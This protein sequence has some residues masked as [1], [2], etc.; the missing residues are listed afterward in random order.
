MPFLNFESR[1]FSEAEITAVNDALQNLHTT[2]A[3]KLASL[4]PEER[5]QYGS[6]NE[7][8]KLL[9]NK[10]NDYKN[11]N[12]Q[13]SSPEVDWEEFS[14]DHE[15]RSFLESVTNT[16]TELGRGLENAKILHDWDNYQASLIDYQYS[17]Y[18]NDSGSTG[19]H[20]K[21]QEIKQFFGRT[22]SGKTSGD[23][24]VTE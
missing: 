23:S 4:T 5:Q 11:S 9:V 15:S 8:N 19:F 16:L 6:I 18:R 13:L 14:K 2:L 12:P 20:T 22:G 21:V 24:T 10:V 17:V 1:H 7:Q 3:G